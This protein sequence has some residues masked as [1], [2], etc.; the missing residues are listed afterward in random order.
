MGLLMKALELTLAKPMD[1]QCKFPCEGGIHLLMGGFA[2]IGYLHGKAGLRELLFECD[3]SAFGSLKLNLS[4]K[5]CDKSL[6]AL[7]LVCYHSMP[8]PLL[9]VGWPAVCDCGSS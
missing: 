2:S 7:S 6:R 1:M 5:E 8:L 4:G 9:A 3:V